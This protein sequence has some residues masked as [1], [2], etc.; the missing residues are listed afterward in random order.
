MKH[1]M[2]DYYYEAYEGTGGKMGR[3]VM[4]EETP[5]GDA[6]YPLIDDVAADMA[7]DVVVEMLMQGN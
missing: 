4:L 5:A 1:V 6:I 3:I 2:N 7:E